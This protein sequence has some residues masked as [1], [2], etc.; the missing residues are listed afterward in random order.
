M[1]RRRTAAAPPAAAPPAA[2]PPG[3]SRRG[4][5]P[6]SSKQ[7]AIQRIKEVYG[8]LPITRLVKAMRQ[9]EKNGGHARLR[10]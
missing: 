6:G 10:A 7:E 3:R 4:S 2:A 8:N 9:H 1:A 5:R